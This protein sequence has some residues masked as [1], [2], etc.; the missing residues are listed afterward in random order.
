LAARQHGLVTLAQLLAAGLDKSAIARRV[1]AGTLH[2]VYRGYTRSVMP[3]S[4]TRGA[5]WRRFLGR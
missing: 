2:R 4:H 3:G 5:S 1:R